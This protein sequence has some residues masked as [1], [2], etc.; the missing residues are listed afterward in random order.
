MILSLKDMGMGTPTIISF[1]DVWFYARNA[2]VSLS[3]S[4][5]VVIFHSVS[6][7]AGPSTPAP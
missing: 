3:E 7:G 6:G 2:G 5:T 1:A 4:P